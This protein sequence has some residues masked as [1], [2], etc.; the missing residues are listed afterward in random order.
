MSIGHALVNLQRTAKLER[1]I[2]KFFV[3]QKSLTAIYVLGFGF[4]RR[5]A[6]AN[7]QRDDDGDDEQK[8]GREV[9]AALVIFHKVSVNDV[10]QT[11][12]YRQGVTARFGRCAVVFIGGQSFRRSQS[13]N[14]K[15]CQKTSLA[16]TRE[17]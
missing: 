5:R 8:K 3:F 9:S 16:C 1:G 14:L 7:C 10:T 12:G 13:A 15:R 11:V 17:S 4:F 2:L 6:G